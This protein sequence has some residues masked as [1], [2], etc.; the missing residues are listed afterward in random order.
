MRKKTKLLV[1][2]VVIWSN[3]VV[4]IA[5]HLST[6]ARI[7]DISLLPTTHLFEMLRQTKW[8]FQIPSGTRSLE[9]G[10][11]RQTQSRTLSTHISQTLSTRRRRAQDGNA[12]EVAAKAKAGK[13][14]SYRST[15]KAHRGGLAKRA[16]ME[17]YGRFPRRNEW[18]GPEENEREW[19]MTWISQ[20]PKPP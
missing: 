15:G 2:M 10:S 11:G 16:M 17:Q 13:D 1:V 9:M 6:A 8:L 19:S 14:Y 3:V 18:W 5:S 20:F 12:A 4:G 7:F